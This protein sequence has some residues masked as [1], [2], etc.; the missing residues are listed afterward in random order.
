MSSAQASNYRIKFQENKCVHCGACLAVCFSQALSQDRVTAKV[1]F[2][3][4]SCLNCGACVEACPL[5][6]IQVS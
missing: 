3:R 5:K 6:A 4:Q 1:F 2:N